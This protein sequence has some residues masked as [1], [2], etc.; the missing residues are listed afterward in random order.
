MTAP[1]RR[2][3]AILAADVAGY[4]RLMGEDEAR[5]LAALRELRNELF[6]PLITDHRG[7]VVKRM[8]DGWLVEFAS[9]VDAV[10][11]AM[12]V[13]ESLTNHEVIKLRMGIHIG[14]IV[15]EDEDIYGDGVNI[16]ARLQELAAPGGIALSDNARRSLDNK[17]K[18]GFRDS[19]EQQLK[20]ISEAVR[21]FILGSAEAEASNS[22][23]SAMGVLPLQD[24]P[25]IAV[26]AFENMSADPQQEFFADGMAEEII[27]ALSRYRW[28]FVIAR[29]SSFTYKGKAVDVKRVSQELGVRYVLEGSVRKAG[30]RIRVATQ[31]IDGASGNS[32]WADRYEREVADIFALQDEIAETIVTAIEP[33][34]GAVERERARR[35]P[36]DNLDAWSSYQR[37]LWHFYGDMTRDG[38]AEAR[39]LIQR[40]CDLDRGFASAFA[41][42]SYT[43]VVDIYLGFTDSS[44]LSLAQAAQAA[45]KA[46]ALD[47]RDPLAHCALGRIYYLRHEYDRAIAEMEAALRL[48]ASFD[49]AYFGLGLA[50]L[51]GGRPQESI[52][53][54]ETAIR[55]SPRGPLLWAY[56]NMLGRAHFNLGRYEEAAIWAEK[57]IQ[58]PNAAFA[59]YL[60]AAAT[61]GHMGRIDEARVRFVE[62]KSRNADFSADTLEA[63]TTPG[64]E[65][66]IDGLRKA[67]LL[68]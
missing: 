31:L 13:Q 40:A 37:G 27:T 39:Q 29:N 16:A 47:A 57:S 26:L 1:T 18:A 58:Q 50:L 66:I 46:V 65:Q 38:I 12:E 68:D 48:N 54:L 9:V 35:N 60:L 33:E 6:E 49:R 56:L 63:A 55:L 45:E 7:Q 61:M 22:N 19:G 20:N 51:Y 42:L 62:M 67:D 15:H 21:V 59:P 32:I 25:S 41:E 24:K 28:F 3:A 8:G 11:C 23:Q 64:V 34:L 17:L 52:S 14:D 36:P 44:D 30:N 43:H 2:L 53:P 10:N 5:T 4:S